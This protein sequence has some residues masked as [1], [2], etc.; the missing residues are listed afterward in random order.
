MRRVAAVFV[1]AVCL[2]AAVLAGG[3]SGEEQRDASGTTPAGPGP[4]ADPRVLAVVE[5]EAVTV[6][7]FEQTYIDL[8]VRSGGNDTAQNR[9]AHLDYLI[10]SILLADAFERT[11]AAESDDFQQFVRRVEREE[12]GSRFFETGLIDTMSAPTEEQIRQAF[13]RSREKAVVRHLFFTSPVEAEASWKRLEAGTPFP[14]EARRV[15]G[16]AEIDSMAGYLGAIG[17][18]SMDDAF[19]EA[20]WELSPGSWSRPV[21]TRFGWH[22]ILLDQLVTSPLLTESQYQMARPGISS[23]YRLRRRRLEGDTF[24]RRFMEARG[25]EVNA[26]AI[27]A[28]SGLIQ[29]LDPAAG[30]PSGVTPALESET[31]AAEIDENVVLATYEWEG[32]RAAFTAGEYAFWLESLP[33]REARERTAASVGRALRNEVLARAAAEQ[34]LRD[35]EWETEVRRRVLLE[36]ATRMRRGL[37]TDI[38]NIDTLLI[39]QAYER[40]GLADRTLRTATF[41]AATFAS[42]QEAEKAL[43]RGVTWTESYIDERLEDIPEWNPWAWTLPLGQPTVVGRTE[44]WAVIRVSNR[45]AKPVSWERHRDELTRELAPRVREFE[46]VR[47]LRKDATIRVDTTL[48]LEILPPPPP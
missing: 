17:Y 24:V 30:D 6:S 10:D 42:R 36:S 15:Y 23:Q 47:A 25:V 32:D 4:D 27:T 11:E 33:Q 38:S 5:G 45:N 1:L 19:A 2:C 44:D 28:L 31:L 22:I 3:C 26:A 34:G 7:W 20:A 41:Q 40:L 29:E 16:L 35:A 46:A 13:R 37:R 21:R 9:W 12:L 8:L 14:E 18:Y 39:R 48:F 43:E